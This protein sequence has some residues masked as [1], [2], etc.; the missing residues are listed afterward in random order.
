MLTQ[1]IVVICGILETTVFTLAKDS[2][3]FLKEVVLWLKDVLYKKRT[4]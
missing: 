2:W 4:S 3:P 1:K